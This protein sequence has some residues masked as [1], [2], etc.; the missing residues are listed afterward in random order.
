MST[1]HIDRLNE[2]FEGIADKALQRGW[3][4]GWVNTTDFYLDI[5]VRDEQS[6]PGYHDVSVIFTGYNGDGSLDKDTAYD[7]ASWL[8]GKLV[9]EYRSEVDFDTFG[10]IHV[11]FNDEL[12]VKN[13]YDLEDFEVEEED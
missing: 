2:I 5:Y 13:I 1:T 4:S 6:L 11:Y 12:I 10:Y 3:M 9:E 7:V 8:F